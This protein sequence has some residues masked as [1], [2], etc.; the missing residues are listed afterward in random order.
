MPAGEIFHLS[1]LCKVVSFN[2]PNVEA[3]FNIEMPLL[4][5]SASSLAPQNTPYASPALMHQKAPQMHHVT[6]SSI[7]YN[8]SLNFTE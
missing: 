3:I 6:K 1:F 7:I 5:S 8:H 4:L 2:K